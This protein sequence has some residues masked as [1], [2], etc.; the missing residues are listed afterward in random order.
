MSSQAYRG[1]ISRAHQGVVHPHA[2][3]EGH[4]HKLTRTTPNVTV[5]DASQQPSPRARLM[6]TGDAA[7]AADKELCLHLNIVFC[8]N[9]FFVCLFYS[10]N[11]N[12]RVTVDADAAAVVRKS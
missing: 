8:I 12:P 6:A 9:C 11:A 1:S 7:L 10:Q 5:T 3:C 4:V 2:N